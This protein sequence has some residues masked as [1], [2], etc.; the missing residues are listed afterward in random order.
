[1]FSQDYEIRLN[2]NGLENS[3]Y[4][5]S[6]QT[7]ATKIKDFLATR[8]LSFGIIGHSYYHLLNYSSENNYFDKVFN[9]VSRSEDDRHDAYIL[10]SKNVTETDLDYRVKLVL[11]TMSPYDTITIIEQE[12]IEA[13]VVAA[14]SEVA[15]QEGFSLIDNSEAEV[16]GLKVL[17]KYMEQIHART[18]NISN[19]WQKSGW[20]SQALNP[21]E[22]FT[23]TGLPSVDNSASGGGGIF[24]DY[25]GLTVTNS[26]G[27]SNLRDV[28]HQGATTSDITYRPDSVFANFDHGYIITSS[29]TSLLDMKRAKVNF[30]S[31]QQKFILWC[32]MEGDSMYTKA[33]NNLSLAETEDLANFYFESMLREWYPEQFEIIVALKEGDES[34]LKTATG[35]TEFKQWGK[36]CLL[37]FVIE[38]PWT[39]ENPIGFPQFQSGFI[40]GLLDGLI[41][42]IS[43]LYEAGDGIFQKTKGFFSGLVD[44]SIDLWRHYQENQTIWSLFEKVGEDTVEIIKAQWESVIETY[45][46]LKTLVSSLSV[47]DM[48]ALLNSLASMAGIWLGDFIEGEAGPAYDVGVIA[49]EVVLA[50][51]TGGGTAAV[52]E[53]TKAGSKVLPKILNFLQDLRNPNGNGFG[54]LM[55]SA[56]TSASKFTNGVPDNP[57]A[58]S[59]S[60]LCKIGV[61]GCFVAGTPVLLAGGLAPI[62][63]IQ[64]LD[65]AV[66]HQTINQPSDPEAYDPYTSAQQRE[67]DQYEIDSVN[68]FEVVFQPQNS[69][70]Y[71]KLALHRDW[72]QKEG[73]EKVGQYHY[74][75][76]PEQGISGLSE[77]TSIR[78]ILPQ[79]VPIDEDTEDDYG[80]QPVT[81]I[82]VHESDDVWTLT[83]DNGDTLG[84]TFNHPFWSV[85]AGWWRLAGELKKGD[86]VQLVNG[87]SLLETNKVNEPA[88]VTYGIEV[89]QH[90]NYLVGVSSIL[91]HNAC[92]KITKVLTSSSS[93]RR[94]TNSLPTQLNPRR[95]KRDGRFEKY[96]TGDDT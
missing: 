54:W 30:N 95:G 91:V 61:G 64:L 48:K 11:P 35:C 89:Y 57:V 70:S 85:D 74:L 37:P 78:H 72:M 25:V 5:Q 56:F 28:L 58:Y 33:T 44:Y 83:F 2:Y 7:E 59:K 63:S 50:V 90:H 29:S 13:D 19:S 24:Y 38:N 20:I 92:P 39:L 87:Y 36:N 75:S 41:G 6:L 51:F 32:H 42:T 49:F 65:Y 76:L 82:F 55:D 18:F 8:N 22:T 3:L 53:A 27:T 71:C 14:I 40:I 69:K 67:R 60:L 86:A 47:A 93:F 77:I 10:I 73:I 34:L 79:K 52:K 21:N 46:A 80:F 15:S 94:W 23:E 62:D 12:A 84:V 16:A 26:E 88:R 81:G 17:L 4:D 31:A 68:W 66:A 45:N 43:M 1:M 9:I 96:A